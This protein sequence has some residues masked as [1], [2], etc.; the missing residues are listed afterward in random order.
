MPISGAESGRRRTLGAG[1]R[2]GWRTA[3]S[4]LAWRPARSR[5]AH[6]HDL[7]QQ[8]QPQRQRPAAGRQQLLRPAVAGRR[9][10]RH[11]PQSRRSGRFLHALH[12]HLCAGHFRQRA[13]VLR[14]RQEQGHA[15]RH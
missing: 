7:L 3:S 5:V 10:R 1:G 12:R 15:D 11:H 8:Q 2:S 13:R 6:Y 4:A 14:R 9:P